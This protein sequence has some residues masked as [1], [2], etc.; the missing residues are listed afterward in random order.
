M[1]ACLKNEEI[2]VWVNPGGPNG[3]RP[4]CTPE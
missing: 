4:Q 3:P 2:A 1:A